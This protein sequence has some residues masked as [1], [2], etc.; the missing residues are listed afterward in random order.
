[1]ALDMPSLF[2]VR[3]LLKAVESHY[4]WYLV[5]SCLLDTSLWVD[6]QVAGMGALVN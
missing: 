3:L 6:N 5:Q 4:I 1:M 2:L